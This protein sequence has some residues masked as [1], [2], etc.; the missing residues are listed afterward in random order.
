MASWFVLEQLALETS[1]T[2]TPPRPKWQGWGKRW[3]G[4]AAF[5]ARRALPAAPRT[6]AKVFL[7]APQRR[8]ARLLRSSIHRALPERKLRRRL[9]KVVATAI[10]GADRH[11][12]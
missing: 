3:S 6:A 7:P 9:Q 11:F 5:P 10:R 2:E 1:F 8:L 12:P 4:P